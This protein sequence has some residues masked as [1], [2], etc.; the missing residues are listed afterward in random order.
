VEEDPGGVGARPGP[1]WGL[2]IPLSSSY[3]WTEA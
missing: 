3:A 1:G 2:G